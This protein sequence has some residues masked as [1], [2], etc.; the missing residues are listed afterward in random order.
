MAVAQAS[1]LTSA[2]IAVST[3]FLLHGVASGMWISRI[4]AVQELLNLGLAT[5]GLALLGAGVGSLLSML[6]MGA[7][8]ARVGSRRVALGAGL[9]ASVAFVLLALASDAWTLFGALVVWGAALGTLDVAMNAQGS[10][11]EQRRARPIMS[12]LHGL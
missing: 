8:I 6:P 9:A 2:R 5:L 11:I 3:I 12:S 10:A 7:L 4:P 1:N